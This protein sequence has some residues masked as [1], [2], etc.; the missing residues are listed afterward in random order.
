MFKLSAIRVACI[1]TF[2]YTQAAMETQSEVNS[3]VKKVLSKIAWSNHCSD[4]QTLATAQN[5]VNRM[6]AAGQ[7]ISIKDILNAQSYARDK[8]THIDVFGGPDRPEY[9]TCQEFIAY[10][11]TV[12][13]EERSKINA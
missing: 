12:L 3:P 5:V 7:R 4:P 2:L 6:R 8:A 10:L 11:E 1:T 13:E 9:N